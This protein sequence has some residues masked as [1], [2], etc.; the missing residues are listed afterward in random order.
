MKKYKVSGDRAYRG[1]EPGEQFTADLT[2]AEERRAVQRGSIEVVGE[3]G[4]GQQTTLDDSTGDEPVKSPPRGG[5]FGRTAE[6]E[7]EVSDG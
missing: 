7:K 2:D 4:A 6:E 1:Y 5:L 3:N